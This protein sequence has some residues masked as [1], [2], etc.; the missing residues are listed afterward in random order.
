MEPLIQSRILAGLA[1]GQV[2]A[3][4]ISKRFG[5]WD[6]PRNMSEAIA[7]IHR[8]AVLA[9]ELITVG[10]GDSKN[11]KDFTRLEEKLADIII[12]TLDIAGG[13]NLRVAAAVVA[14]LNHNDQL[15]KL[16]KHD[17]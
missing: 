12:R 4:E 11:L 10:D 8:D 2:E 1:F 7:S 5:H 15:S 3:F 14:K 9:L 16:V 13:K 17:Y 6:Q